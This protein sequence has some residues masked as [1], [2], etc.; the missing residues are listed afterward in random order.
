MVVPRLPLSSLPVAGRS[1]DIPAPMLGY[2]CPRNIQC[3]DII[4]PGIS[5]PGYSSQWGIQRLDILGADI[6]KRWACLPQGFP[7]LARSCSEAA[8]RGPEAAPRT[9]ARSGDRGL[10][11]AASERRLALLAD[12]KYSSPFRLA[13]LADRKYSPPFR[14][15]PLADC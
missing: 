15:A 3:L 14:L 1:L 11:A 9:D 13:S 2:S 5:A 7:R 8:P 10:G 4:A 12:C 6:S